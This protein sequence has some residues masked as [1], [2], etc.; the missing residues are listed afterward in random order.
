M[1]RNKRKE[2]NTQKKIQQKKLLSYVCTVNIQRKKPCI[3]L[4][5]FWYC[6]NI[7]YVVYHVSFCFRVKSYNN[8]S[9]AKKSIYKNLIIAAKINKT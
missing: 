1:K 2:S 9:W 5:L 7:F 3:L 4:L 6:F 8:Y